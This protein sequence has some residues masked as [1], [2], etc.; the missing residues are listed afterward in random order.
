MKS[1]LFVLNEFLNICCS[2]YNLYV[3]ELGINN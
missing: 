2:H 3:C 1:V